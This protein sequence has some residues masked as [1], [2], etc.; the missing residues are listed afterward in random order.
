MIRVSGIYYKQ[1]STLPEKVAVADQGSIPLE[2]DDI[3]TRDRVCCAV[4]KLLL[5]VDDQL[6]R[7]ATI[8][9]VIYSASQNLRLALL[10]RA[11][12]ANAL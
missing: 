9:C 6:P 1:A 7:L 2:L 10:L 12:Q 3:S 11:C 4:L 8:N 5:S